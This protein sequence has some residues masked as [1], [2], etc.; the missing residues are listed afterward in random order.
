MPP[1]LLAVCR[2]L[3]APF[4]ISSERTDVALSA[5]SPDVPRQRC[6]RLPVR[7]VP[8]YRVE[9]A[10]HERHDLLGRDRLPPLPRCVPVLLCSF[11]RHAGV[12]LAFLKDRHY[13]P[14]TVRRVSLPSIEQVRGDSAARRL[15]QSI[16]VSA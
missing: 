16:G 12:Q 10:G 1:A 11:P 4:T 9:D 3:L 7:D 5:E 14:P 8:P 6:P 15:S 13:I 2:S